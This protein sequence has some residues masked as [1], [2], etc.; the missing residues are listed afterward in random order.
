VLRVSTVVGGTYW[1]DERQLRMSVDIIDA[2]QNRQIWSE[3]FRSLLSELLGLVDR[4]VPKV[5]EALRV[6]LETKPEREPLG[7]KK[8]PFVL[9]YHALYRQKK[10]PKA[11]L[12]ARN[13]PRRLT[14]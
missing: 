8:P 10:R 7:T 5:A 6:R 3:S 2:R 9:G 1:R 13:A 12:T 11:P 4:I 14:L